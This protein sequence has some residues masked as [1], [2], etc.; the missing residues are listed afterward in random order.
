MRRTRRQESSLT[1]LRAR[2]PDAANYV[3]PSATR[4][5][6]NCISTLIE[7]WHRA[8]DAHNVGP[9]ASEYPAEDVRRSRLDSYSGRC[10]DRVSDVM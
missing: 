5:F 3:A 7:A 8:A 2:R 6:L 9:P 10:A 4:A 1:V